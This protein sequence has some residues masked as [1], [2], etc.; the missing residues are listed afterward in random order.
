MKAGTGHASMGTGVVSMAKGGG[1][2]AAGAGA[3]TTAGA[4]PVRAGGIFE[5]LL[6]RTDPRQQRLA[7]GLER[8]HGFR[9]LPCLIGT[10]NRP[11]CDRYRQ[12]DERRRRQIWIAGQSCH[13]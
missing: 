1:A 6:E 12:R 9:Q 4:P 8:T 7:L 13:E 5:V 3:R 11:F 2:A 10:L